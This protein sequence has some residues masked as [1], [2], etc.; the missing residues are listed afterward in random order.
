MQQSVTMSTQEETQIVMGGQAQVEQSTGGSRQHGRVAQIPPQS[1]AD[2][3]R[4]LGHT[5][6]GLN[7]QVNDLRAH[8]AQQAAILQVMAPHWLLHGCDP[9]PVDAV[10]TI[11]SL[12]TQLD[13]QKAYLNVV[14]E[15]HLSPPNIQLLQHVRVCH[16]LD[17][18]PGS[19]LA[20]WCCDMLQHMG[21]YCSPCSDCVEML[22]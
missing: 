16:S 22:Q 11:N 17:T 6:S 9:D 19:C 5:I 12:L 20:A 13:S 18:F 3:E 8:S 10:Q 4:G 2:K 14:E 15:L 21:C 1:A 7:F